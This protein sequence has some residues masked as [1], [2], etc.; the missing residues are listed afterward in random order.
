MFV[1]FPGRDRK[2]IVTSSLILPQNGREFICRNKLAPFFF[3]L[4]QDYGQGLCPYS[5]RL[6]RETH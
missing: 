2:Y 5:C 6:R 1:A 4:D 3:R